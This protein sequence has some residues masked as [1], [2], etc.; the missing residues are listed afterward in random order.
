VNESGR[1][2]SF[3][4]ILG[5]S[6]VLIAATVLGWWIGRPLGPLLALDIAAGALSWLLAPLMVWR[7]V[8]ATAVLTVLAALSPAATPPATMGMLQV[9]RRR[10]VPVAIA[11]AVGGVA[12]HA[13]QGAWRANGGLSYGWWLVLVTI[14]YG[15]LLGWGAWARARAA[16]IGSLR[17]RA[18]RAEEERD[19]RV[20]E[21]RAAER[22][23]IAHEMHDV[24]AH[25]LTLVATYAGA[26]EY[27][28]D[29]PAEQVA[30]AAGVVRA[31]VHQA[32]EELRDV[33]GV[34]RTGADEPRPT[35][36][37]ADVPRLV[38][39]ARGV[40]QQIAFTDTI[41]GTPPDGVGRT[42]YRLVQEGLS[43]ARRHA[44]GKPVT[45]RLS[46]RS[47]AEVCVHMKNDMAGTDAT[48]PPGAG[49][50]GLAER[51]GL[52]GGRFEHETAEGAFHLRARLPWPE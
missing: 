19:R 28:P 7:P 10:R 47:G 13:V 6:G 41:E 2:F 36:V 42:V 37:F 32:L 15:A 26:L 35:P 9:A 45:V 48:R 25:R 33:I 49:L 5:A 46:G 31:G 24:L 11:V 27:R 30:K 1:R 29:A 40:G 22:T 23:R 50:I 14:G 34:L 44:A 8:A 20:A 39:E 43:N 51:V 4:L 38:E 18:R 12:A 16:L 21:A 52:A 3:V 17:D